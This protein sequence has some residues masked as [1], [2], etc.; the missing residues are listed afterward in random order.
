VVGFQSSSL[1]LDAHCIHHA[2]H[3]TQPAALRADQEAGRT[4]ARSAEAPCAVGDG[5]VAHL[6]MEGDEEGRGEGWRWRGDGEE[7]ARRRRSR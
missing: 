5:L 7:M 3:G 4:A 1:H 2:K 6:L